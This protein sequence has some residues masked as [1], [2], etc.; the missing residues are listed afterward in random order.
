MLEKVAQ[1]AINRPI[2][3]HWLLLLGKKVSQNWFLD[4]LSMTAQGNER[5]GRIAS[6][7]C[8]SKQKSSTNLVVVFRQFRQE[9]QV[10]SCGHGVADEEDLLVAGLVEDVV[11]GGGKVVAG[12][13]VEAG[14]QDCKF[15][16]ELVTL[17]FG[18]AAI[19]QWIRLRLPSFCPGFE[20][21]AHHLCFYQFKFK[22][23]HVEKTKI[24]RK[25][26]GIANF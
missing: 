26:A 5:I 22:L 16:S 21:Q 25:E 13:F 7:G 2:W 10:L 8:R 12:R 20:S 1:S 23:C 4:C 9:D 3:S 14:T 11:D 15:E 17:T 24:S 19:A 6:K 18:G